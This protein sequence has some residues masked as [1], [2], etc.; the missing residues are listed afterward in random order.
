MTESQFAEG[1]GNIADEHAR[2]RLRAWVLIVLGLLLLVGSIYQ[3]FAWKNS[4]SEKL[5]RSPISPLPFVQTAT[6]VLA[7]NPVILKSGGFISAKTTAQITA[8]VSGKIVR[9]SPKLLTGEQVKKGDVLVQLEVSDYQAAVAN[10]KAN[11]ASMQSTYAQEQ[12]R[13]RQAR[14]DAK[15][16]EVKPTDLLLR[17]PQVAAA[18]AA[19]ANAK[20][21]LALAEANLSRA[22]IY[23]PFNAVINS[24]S[25]ALGEIANSGSTLATLAGTDV[26]TVRLTINSNELPLVSIGDTVVLTDST[27]GYQHHG[28]INRLD[29]MFDAK[30][31]TVGAYI[32]IKRPLANTKP[33]VLNDYIKARIKGKNISNSAWVDNSAIVENRLVWRKKADDTITPVEIKVIYRG[34]TQTLVTFKDVIETLIIRPK[35]TFTDGQKVTTDASV[36]VSKKHQE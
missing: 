36:A 10:A 15:R 27:Y 33:L 2:Y 16:L 4:Q 28:M 9:L 22:T 23:A 14:R 35:D 21:Q 17:K 25:A 5:L 24:S 11:L 26:F 31:R 32:D 12:G 30:N 8:Q 13:A 1:S 19:V 3:F 6:V 29:A 34:T 20:A 18:K 7:D